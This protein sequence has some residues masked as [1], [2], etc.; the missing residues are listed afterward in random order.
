[1]LD[2]VDADAWW[3]AV[4][5]VQP[6]LIRV[7]ADEVTY[8]LHILVRFEIELA[9]IRG[10]LTVAD[11]P[12][13]FDAA[14]ERYLGIRPPHVGDGV[15]Q[16][17]HWASGS[18]GYF[19]TYTLGNLYAAQMHEAAARELGDLDEQVRRGEFAPLL[20]W[21]RERIHHQGH[22]RDAEEIARAATG[23]GLEHETFMRYLRGKYGAIYGVTA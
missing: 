2:D 5:L 16:D 12:E 7:E 18:F 3:R 15:L 11:L 22:L 6:S 4:N 1:V 23:R 8:N 10:E 21:L 17:V 9:L 14:L 13:A 19:P 20:G